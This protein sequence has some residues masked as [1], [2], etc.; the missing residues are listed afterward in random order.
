MKILMK[1]E[2]QQ[3]IYFR[4]QSNLMISIGYKRVFNE[5][6]KCVQ[7]EDE[8]KRGLDENVDL[9]GKKCSRAT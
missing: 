2:S 1:N 3:K 6:E 4:I 8:M 9:Q 5:T 7:K